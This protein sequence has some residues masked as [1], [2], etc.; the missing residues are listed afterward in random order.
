MVVRHHPFH[1]NR[2]CLWR[3]DV[4]QLG[5]LPLLPRRKSSI[6]PNKC[7]PTNP[8]QIISL[9][10]TIVGLAAVGLYFATLSAV[11]TLAAGTP[12][13]MGLLSLP[14]IRATVNQLFLFLATLSVTSGFKDLSSVALC[15]TQ[16]VPFDIAIGVG[17]GLS[18]IFVLG[19]SI[20]G[21]DMYLV[22]RDARQRKKA[23][24]NKGK[25]IEKVVIDEESLERQESLER[26]E[27]NGPEPS[28]GPNMI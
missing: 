22:F 10:T 23:L 15:F 26:L 7:P 4:R 18:T 20:M 8:S 19:S 25:Q 24:K 27:G 12:P 21:I 17:F 2:I 11:K 3:R 1:H 9:I 5:S 16:V 28:R 6:F 14:N 13:P